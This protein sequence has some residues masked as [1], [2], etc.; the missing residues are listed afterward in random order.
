M[1]DEI[2]LTP[3][4]STAALS[5]CEEIGKS[6][7]RRIKVITAGKQHCC[8]YC[9][10]FYVE[11]STHLI[12]SRCNEEEVCA[13]KKIEINSKERNLYESTKIEK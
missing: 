8:F 10:I 3:E 4:L 2:T 9:K 1:R 5:S 11:M 7:L 6:Q 12:C 13:I